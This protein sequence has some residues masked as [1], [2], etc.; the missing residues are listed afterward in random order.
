MRVRRMVVLGYFGALSGACSSDSGGAAPPETIYD[1]LGSDKGVKAIVDDFYSRLTNDTQ[2]NG[3]FLNASLDA[4]NLKACLVK[5]IGKLTGGPDTYD[6]KDMKAAHAGLG[7]SQSDFDDLVKDLTD[8][9]AAAK[10]SKTD[11]DKIVAV[12]GPMADDVV[13]D[14]TNDADIYQRIGR[15]PAIQS[16]VTA[17]HARVMNDAAINHFFANVNANRLAACLVRQACG[18]TGG[19]CKYGD[20]VLNTAPEN[21]KSACRTME[22]AHSGLHI[23]KADFDELVSDLVT[24]IDAADVAQSDRDAIVGALAPLCP[25][26]VEGGN[27]G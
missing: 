14:K 13:E 6:C 26:I 18:A 2:I 15:K 21:L 7:I 16:L 11:I 23:M 12:L 17:F 20:E 10:V 3:Y 8:A 22:D 1:R 24:E 9:L 4:D 5:Q 27:C 25:K 19:P